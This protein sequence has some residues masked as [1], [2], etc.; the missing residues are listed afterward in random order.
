M[1]RGKPA[2][3]RAFKPHQAKTHPGG[4]RKIKGG[5]FSPNSPTG[6]QTAIRS[7]DYAI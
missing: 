3:T 6:A 5:Y 7:D 4:S 2:R 1:L